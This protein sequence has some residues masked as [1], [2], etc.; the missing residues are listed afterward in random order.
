MQRQRRQRVDTPKAPQPRDG[1]PQPSVLGEPREALLERVAASDQ[2]V[3]GGEQVDEDQLGRLMIERL[4]RQPLPVPDVPSGRLAID[5]ALDQQQ[6]GDPVARAH[7]IRPDLLAPAREMPHRLDPGVRDE[8]RR[9]LPREQQP[10]EQFGVLAIGLDPIRRRP[11]RLA[12]RDHLHRDPGRVGGA[13]EPKPRRTRLINRPHRP[14]QPRQPLD[15]RLDPRPEPDPVELPAQRVDRRPV[16]RA[17]MDVKSHPC[18]RSGH[19]RTLLRLGSAGAQ[20][21]G[22]TNPRTRERVRPQSDRAA[23]SI[24]GHSV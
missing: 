6:L 7:H 1:R 22:Q 21:S 23:D 20:I 15:H 8:H 24:N 3:Q 18:H 14:R 4:P 19:G 9:Q 11:R 12:R 13:L 2:P 16:R 10:G 5:A 17:R